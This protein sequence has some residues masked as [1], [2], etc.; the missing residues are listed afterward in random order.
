MRSA[1]RGRSM[2]Y[3][4]LSVFFVPDRLLNCSTVLLPRAS[5]SA[6]SSSK[7]LVDL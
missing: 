4:S 6:W 7:N 2:A 5:I 1:G 3:A